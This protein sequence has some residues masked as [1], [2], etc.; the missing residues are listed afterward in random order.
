MRYVGL[1][2]PPDDA[3]DARLKA[4]DIVAV[5]TYASHE[6]VLREVLMTSDDIKTAQI[7]RSYFD[8]MRTVDFD[9]SRIRISITEGYPST[10]KAAIIEVP[11]TNDDLDLGRSKKSAGI[12]LASWQR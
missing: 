2:V 5:L 9:G 7:M 3:T 8:S 1:E 10:P 11:V 6:R 4:P 12:E